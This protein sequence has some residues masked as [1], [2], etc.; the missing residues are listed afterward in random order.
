MTDLL[1]QAII[2]ELT[3]WDRRHKP[4]PRLDYALCNDRIIDVF[5]YRCPVENTYRVALVGRDG[6]YWS[7]PEWK[8]GGQMYGDGP[9]H[10]PFDPGSMREV[11]LE[12]TERQGTSDFGSTDF[13]WSSD[14]MD[15]DPDPSS[16]FMRVRVG[17]VKY[18]AKYL[19]DR[20][21]D[22]TTV[23][24]LR[25][26][27][28]SMRSAQARHLRAFHTRKWRANIKKREQALELV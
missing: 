24:P 1:D 27:E 17:L 21:P 18:W 9:A 28:T 20:R 6:V 5:V 7:M 14:Q 19:T 3:R 12:W 2:R 13:Q 25:A 15:W 8:A 23:E 26:F 10:L 22:I 11:A 16:G 4:I